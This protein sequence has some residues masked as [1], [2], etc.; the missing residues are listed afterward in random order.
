MQYDKE[1]KR[2]RCLEC[3]DILPYGRSDMKFC[4]VR[5]KSRWHYHNF[6]RFR[7]AR[8]KIIRT[9]DRNHGILESLLDAGVSSID[10][11]DLEQ[12]GYDLGCVTSYHKVRRHGEYRCYDIKYYMTASRV[13]K[14]EK[15]GEPDCFRLL[16][17]PPPGG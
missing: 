14:L 12:R 10:L 3:G 8:Q 4:S 2:G 5:C 13:F 17:D 7:G 6:G 15:T 16:P 9:L 11:P 1:E